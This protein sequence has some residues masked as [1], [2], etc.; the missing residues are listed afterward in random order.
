MAARADL[1]QDVAVGAALRRQ[2]ASSVWVAIA[3]IT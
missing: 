3:C 2:P 1:A